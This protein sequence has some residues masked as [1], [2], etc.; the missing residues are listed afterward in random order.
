[1]ATPPR[2]ERRPGVPFG[3]P[4]GIPF[5]LSPA[6]LFTGV[7]AY[8]F[9]PL[10]SEPLTPGPDDYA[11]SAA[12]MALL[13]ASVAAHEVGHAAVSLRLGIPVRR[14]T[15]HLLGGTAETDREPATPVAEYLV[16]V[17]GLHVSVL[18][19]ACAALVAGYTPDGGVA[20]ELAKFLALTNIAVAVVNL[21]P[22]LPLDGGR[23]LRAAV[24]R[25][26]GS[27]HTGTRAA[28]RGGQV[29]ALLG[30]AFGLLRIGAGDQAGFVPL[31]VAAF[32]WM[33]AADV[34]RRALLAERLERIDIRSLIRP[35]LPVAASLPLAEALRRAVEAGERLVVVDAYGAPAGVINGPALAAVPEQRRP[36]VTVA[37]VT[38]M[39][40]PGLVLEPGLDGPRLLERMRA[41]PATEYLVAGPD[42]EVTGVLSAHD[43]ARVLDGRAEAAT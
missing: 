33:S 28:V 7:L 18:I 35:A 12:A 34:H 9:A 13:A 30:A 10:F 20:H 4:L 26:S 17:A 11:A 1:M 41:T 27:R 21:L 2:A 36:W 25:F 22:G 38:R 5:Y 42:G 14:V 8:A 6:W 39:I 15:L 19:A 16:A 32:L 3:R 37:E 40:E 23:L 31:L 24:W 43:V 29:A